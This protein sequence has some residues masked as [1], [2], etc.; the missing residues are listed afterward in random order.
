MILKIIFKSFQIKQF[1]LQDDKY[2][3]HQHFTFVAVHIVAGHTAADHMS[4]LGRMTDHIVVFRKMVVHIADQ[5]VSAGV[6]VRTFVAAA[7]VELAGHTFVGCKWFHGFGTK[8]FLC[9]GTTNR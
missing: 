7:A 3:L 9:K 1:T 6:L 5:T 4:L 8:L 2:I